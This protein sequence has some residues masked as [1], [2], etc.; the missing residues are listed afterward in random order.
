M[1][2]KQLVFSSCLIMSSF[3]SQASNTVSGQS[4]RKIDFPLQVWNLFSSDKTEGVTIISNSLSSGSIRCGVACQIDPEC[5]GFLFDNTS[6]SCTTK[7]VKNVL[8]FKNFLVLNTTD[9]KFLCL[10]NL[11]TPSEAQDSVAIFV[12][13]EKSASCLG[14]LLLNANF[15]SKV[16]AYE[17]HIMLCSIVTIHRFCFI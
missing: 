10:P 5:G 17:K 4:Y 12:K 13:T 7:S 14:M 9:F 8:K 11:K 2:L 15:H 6:G 16:K 1:Y 3:A